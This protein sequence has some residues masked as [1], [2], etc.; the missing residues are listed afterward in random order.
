MTCKFF[1]EWTRDRFS[2]KIVW[3]GIYFFELL[4]G[5][6]GEREIFSP[7]SIVSTQIIGRD[8]LLLFNWLSLNLISETKG[9]G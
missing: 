3:G 5:S 4:A 7:E 8:F 6:T 2:N 1:D 9:W